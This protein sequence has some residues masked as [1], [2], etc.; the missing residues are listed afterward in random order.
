[1]GP[2]RQKPFHLKKIAEVFGS[3]IVSIQ[4]KWT[5]TRL[6]D[7]QGVHSARHLTELFEF[8]WMKSRL[9]SFI[10]KIAESVLDQIERYIFLVF[11][12]C[13]NLPDRLNPRPW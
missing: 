10:I 5:V 6:A 2:K 8:A 7:K 4:I 3:P 11:S 13:I 1:M 9:T 12:C